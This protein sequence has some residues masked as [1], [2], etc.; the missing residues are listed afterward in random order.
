M[1]KTV[2]AKALVEALGIPANH[3]KEGAAAVMEAIQSNLRSK[4]SFTMNGFGT[5]TVA[6]RPARKGRN[7][8]TGETVKVGASRTV[9]FKASPNLRKAMARAKI[10]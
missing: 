3:A 7:P 8:R 5:F 6:S 10:S 4:G 2:I 1:S 9:R